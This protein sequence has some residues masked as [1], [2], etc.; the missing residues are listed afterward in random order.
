[1][2]ARER[3]AALE[4]QVRDGLDPVAEKRRARIKAMTFKEAAERC[5]ADRKGGYDNAKHSAQWL[6]SLETY[7][8]PK[9]KDYP[10]GKVPASAIIAAMKP[11]WTIKPET[12]RRVLQ[13]IGVVV[14]WASSAE[15]R[16]DEVP[17][18]VVRNGL[19]PQPKRNPETARGSNEDGHFIALA[20]VDAPAFMVELAT[21]PSTGARLCLEFLILTAARSGEARGAR[22]S[23]FDF[24]R[25]LWTIPGARMKA[26]RS[27]VVPLSDRALQIVRD[28]YEARSQ[29]ELVFP[30]TKKAAITDSALSKALR[31]GIAKEQKATIHGMRST[32][33]DWVSKQNRY[34]TEAAEKALA[35]IEP[36]KTRQAYERDD[37]LELRR[38]MMQDW[39]D[40][41]FQKSNVITLAAVG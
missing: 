29:D 11:I 10:A 18:R 7:A 30:G 14:A 5:H 26:K 33:R 21:M 28:I 39:A 6:S 3:V 16:D 22:W 1:M 17:M 13:R 37:L 27:H 38:P 4:K 23:E 24:E 31:I 20:H 34:S 8:F 36:S 12:A 19:P 25:A 2:E 32:F 35:H 40:Y 9:L 41:L 15:D